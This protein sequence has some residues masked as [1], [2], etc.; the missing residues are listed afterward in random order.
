M[1]TSDSYTWY[2]QAPYPVQE[3][4]YSAGMECRSQTYQYGVSTYW[5]QSSGLSADASDVNITFY[6]YLDQNPDP[7]INHDRFEFYTRFYSGTT[8]Y[9]LYYILNG[10]TSS[11]NSST[12]GYFLLDEPTQ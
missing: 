3:G 10:T 11:T 1:T 7:T 9:Y 4:S 2:A 8:H 6:W 5:I 12:Q